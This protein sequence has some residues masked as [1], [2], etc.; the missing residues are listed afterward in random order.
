[1]SC[2][3]LYE[4]MPS[5]HF[6]VRHSVPIYKKVRNQFSELPRSVYAQTFKVIWIQVTETANKSNL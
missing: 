5:W 2:L 1:M 3:A 6:Q 4:A